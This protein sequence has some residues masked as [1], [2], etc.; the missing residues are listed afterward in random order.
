MK[1]AKSL[2]GYAQTRFAQPRVELIME[3]VLVT[4]SGQFTSIYTAFCS[5]V[6]YLQTLPYFD[7]PI[8]RK[9]QRHSEPPF[10]SL[11][12]FFF[13]PPHCRCRHNL[14]VDC[15]I[16]TFLKAVGACLRRRVTRYLSCVA[17]AF[18]GRKSADCGGTSGTFPS[19]TL[20]AADAPALCHSDAPS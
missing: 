12:P 19:L 9:S 4:F 13:S 15:F 14:H 1:G 10:W 7:K 11:A 17:S 3:L 2:L 6:H 8:N 18:H 16:V 5:A 20:C